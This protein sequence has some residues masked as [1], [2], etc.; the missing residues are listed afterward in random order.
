VQAF[1][2]DRGLFP[3]RIRVERQYLSRP[4]R[5]PTTSQDQRVP[6]GRAHPWPYLGCLFAFAHETGAPFHRPRV[7]TYGGDGSSLPACSSND[8]SAS[9]IQHLPV[10]R[11][12]AHRF[13]C[14]AQS[15]S[16]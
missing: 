3:H 2:D 12:A 11:G 9:R 13:E 16:T 7:I 15:A 14:E 5:P 6:A 10:D 4:T 1:L 8:S